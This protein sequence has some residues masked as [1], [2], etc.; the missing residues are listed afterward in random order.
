MAYWCH[1]SS[2]GS[3]GMTMGRFATKAPPFTWL[4][5]QRMEPGPPP[6]MKSAVTKKPG[7]CTITPSGFAVMPGPPCGFCFIQN[8][9]VMAPRPDCQPAGQARVNGRVAPST[10]SFKITELCGCEY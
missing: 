3:N 2:D 7:P 8:S 4:K 9:T 10:F 5:L 1:C 6:N